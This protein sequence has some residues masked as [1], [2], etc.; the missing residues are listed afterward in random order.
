M[1]AKSGPYLDAIARG[2][3]SAPGDGN[4]HRG[5]LTRTS[6][7]LASDLY[8]RFQSKLKSLAIRVY[9]PRAS[10]D[11]DDLVQEGFMGLLESWSLFDATRVN[12][13]DDTT[14]WAYAYQRVRG[15][16][17]DELRYTSNFTRR[18]QCL[19]RMEQYEAY[20]HG[21]TYV[22]AEDNLARVVEWIDKLPNNRKRQMVAL[23]IVKGLS[24]LAVGA[25][26]GVSESRAC[27]VIGQTVRKFGSALQ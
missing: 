27:Q 2:E 8:T 1:L 10:A 21:G 13:A 25:T 7:A 24:M 26:Y 20:R 3:R 14:F 19:F 9:D 11:I 16:M 17:V 15:S 4:R 18:D 12:N 5:V 6:D 22:P 23:Y